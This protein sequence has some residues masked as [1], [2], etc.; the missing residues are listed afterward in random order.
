MELLQS[1]KDLSIDRLFIYR[2]SKV[3]AEEPLLYRSHLPSDKLS[4]QRS[5]LRG[6]YGPG[7][8]TSDF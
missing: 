2:R 8:Q 7:G 4:S 5:E 6:L 3:N 1:E